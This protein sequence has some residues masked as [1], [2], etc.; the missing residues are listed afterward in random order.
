MKKKKST[1]PRFGIAAGLMWRRGILVGV[2]W[3]T[4]MSLITVIGA[5]Q[6]QD[7]WVEH[8]ARMTPL[9][10]PDRDDL[11]PGQIEQ[12]RIAQMEAFDRLGEA[13]LDLPFYIDPIRFVDIFKLLD[14]SYETGMV[15]FENG[16]PVL[17]HGDYVTF[18]YVHADNW[19]AGK[20]TADGYAYIDLHM[21]PSDDDMENVSGVQ[22]ERGFYQV[23]DIFRLTGYFEGNRFVLQELAGF[24]VKYPELYEGK[25]LPQWDQERGLDWQIYYQNPQ[26]Q[27]REPV[28]IYTT[29]LCNPMYG[30][31][32]PLTS[33]LME[34]RE[35]PK[36]LLLRPAPHSSE[37]RS[38]LRTVIITERSTVTRDGTYHKALS[39]IQCYPLI[40]AIMRLRYLYYFSLILCIL[41]LVRYYFLIKRRLLSPLRQS[42]DPGQTDPHSS[43]RRKWREPYL[44]ERVCIFNRQQLLQLQQENQQLKTALDYAKNAEINRRQMISGI[45]H[46]LKTP[47]AVIHS[48]C[49]GLQAGIAPEKQE[50]YLSVITEEADR[51]DAMVLEML[52]LSRLEAGKV[53]LAQDQVELLGLTRQILQ[54]FQPLLEE[55]GLTVTFGIVEK[56]PL[57]ADEGRLGQ[58]ITN[59]VSN[60]IKYSPEKGQVVV[61][62]FQRNGVTHFSIENESAPLSEE[63]LEQ[64]WETF[65]RTEQSRTS[66]G[67]GLGLP[68]C[69]AIIELHRGTCHVKNTSTGVEFGFVL[70]G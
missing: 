69:K 46:E 31:S 50:K 12:Q 5:R 54:K 14:T 64:V 34:L 67:T 40:T 1:V 24:S 4:A 70:T 51:M 63:A 20:E 33:L 6:L 41:A 15:Y 68:I 38:L 32:R 25:T 19:A 47:L 35:D 39:V 30:K 29:Q 8:A 57:I 53:R 21:T 49:E 66:K 17:T 13:Y 65:Y 62:I 3:L 23:E 11:L 7:Q 56:S 45:T 27:N 61:N 36:D 58:V 59:L 28:Q 60:A 9:Y 37:S 22:Y 43:G 26:E 52:D 55:K 10:A 48:Y 44:L 42:F 2:L 16:K 18:A